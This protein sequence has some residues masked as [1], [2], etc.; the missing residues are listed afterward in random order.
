MGGGGVGVGEE[1]PH[2]T[3]GGK[4]LRSCSNV[5]QKKKKNIL[6][7]VAP[8]PHLLSM[9]ALHLC[10]LFSCSH[11]LSDNEGLGL[12]LLQC[13]SVKYSSDDPVAMQ[14]HSDKMHCMR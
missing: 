3:S 6:L 8:S 7:T 11:M 2:S 1:S 4:Y 12:M 10:T 14:L 5:K 9:R 13:F